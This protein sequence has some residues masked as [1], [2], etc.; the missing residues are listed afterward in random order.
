MK[1]VLVLA[2]AFLIT[3]A[4]A[5]VVN[6]NFSKADANG[7]PEGWKV[8]RIGKAPDGLVIDTGVCRSPKGALRLKSNYSVIQDIKLKPKTEY[9]FSCWYKTVKCDPAPG[10]NAK[11]WGGG[12]DLALRSVLPNGKTNWHFGIGRRYLGT[13]DWTRVEFKFNSSRLKS[14]VLRIVLSAV[15]IDPEGACWFDDATL[16]EV[17]A[18]KTAVRLQPLDFQKGV[19]YIT[20]NIPG[21][22][23]MDITGD[24]GKLLKQGVQL[25]MK[26]P[27]EFRLIGAVAE[28]TNPD[29]PEKDRNFIETALAKEVTLPGAAVRSFEMPV[30]RQMVR[31]LKQTSY[32]WGNSLFIAIAA[33]PGSRGKSGKAIMSLH[34]AGRE[35]FRYSFVLHALPAVKL[36]EQP[37]TMLVGG[38]A[39][40]ASQFGH[41]PE[42]NDA[43]RKFWN[44]LTRVR[45]S[46]SRYINFYRTY[47]PDFYKNTEFEWKDYGNVPGGL[48]RFAAMKLGRK[49]LAELP[50]LID[51]DGRPVAGALAPWYVA[52]DPDNLIWPAMK[53]VIQKTLEKGGKRIVRIENNFET[54]VDTGYDAENIRRFV[55]FAKLKKTPTRQEIRA[56]YSE[57]WKQYQLQVNARIVRRYADMVHKN[58]PGRL[59]VSCNT[60]L[61]QGEK[62][63]VDVDRRMFDEVVDIHM[64]MC[65]M[66]G[67]LFFDRVGYNLS[68]P[69]KPL[70]VLVDPTE[71]HELYYR[72]YTPLETGRNVVAAAALGA[73]GF[74]FY[75]ADNFDGRYLQYIADAYGTVRKLEKFY[76]RRKNAS[77]VKLT[78]ENVV[79]TR[80]RDD[81]RKIAVSYPE[82][83]EFVRHTLHEAD[84]GEKLLTVF[85]YSGKHSMIFRLTI[86]GGGHVHDPINSLNYPEADWKKGALVEV[87][88]S[89]TGY[90]VISKKNAPAMKNT[91]SQASLQKRLSEDRQ[92]LA[93]SNM[94]VS[95]RQG[96]AEISFARL[97][98][99]GPT[100]MMTMTSGQYR[101]YIDCMNGGDVVGWKKLADAQDD[102]LFAGNTRGFLGR[103]VWLD[104]NQDR[105]PPYAFRILKNG[106]DADGSPWAEFVYT[107]PQYDN[108]ETKLNPLM[109]LET[110]KRITLRDGGK[111]VTVKFTFTN[112]NELKKNIPLEFKINNAPVPGNRFLGSGR[113]SGRIIE[114]GWNSSKGA[115]KLTASDPENVYLVRVPRRDRRKHPVEREWKYSPLTVTAAADGMSESLTVIP[116]DKGIAGVFCWR[117]VAFCTVEPY[118]EVI[119]LKPGEQKIFT[120]EYRR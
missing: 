31:N 120:L 39:Q 14:N 7:R 71:T 32:N 105:R 114:V 100:P 74:H 5:Q 118:S 104:K 96:N 75:P 44:S 3:G 50:V 93:S 11:R 23:R 108:V 52:D 72:R 47:R 119:P 1:N 41:L 91:V 57:L 70:Y 26:L 65:Y 53:D 102:I 24:A 78:P 62:Y 59:F 85:N 117:G 56:V 82:A 35:I 63:P 37:A 86:P 22:N 21:L 48:P 83:G 8:N 60:L 95:K 19:F 101:I 111:R 89:G 49:K 30:P 17:G 43:Y 87:P 9:S 10:W 29:L 76:A 66:S 98:D 36:P 12:C 34:S 115:A 16:E 15:N 109:G 13:T 33:E 6:G 68:I 107:V 92:R 2:V 64:P 103:P 113:T 80:F 25:R 42:V 94:F 45:V 28:R 73:Y 38:I 110:V 20:E 112:K 51:R 90:F 79:T 4:S 84:D 40:P 46:G 77:G 67:V 116:P 106:F 81:G 18:G 55:K 88:P 69:G 97:P 58:F 27:R 61:K 99:T 54:N